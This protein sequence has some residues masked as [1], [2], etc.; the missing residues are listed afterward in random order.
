MPMCLR[1][2]HRLAAGMWGRIVMGEGRMRFTS[3]AA[4]SSDYIVT[5]DAPQA[6]PPELSHSVEPLGAV[7]FVIQFYQP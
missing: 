2:S 5:A 3:E 7:R 4:P 1:R 6:I